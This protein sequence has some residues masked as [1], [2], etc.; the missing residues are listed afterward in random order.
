[1]IRFENL[2]KKYGSFEALKGIT[3]EIRRGEIVGFLG[4]NGAGKTTTMKILTTFISPTSGT[5]DV[6][7]LDIFDDA[8]EI[9]R[10]IGYLPES[11]PL[12]V[13]MQVGEYLNFM[14][15]ARG[16]SSGEI[17]AGRARVAGLCGISDRLGHPINSLSKGYRQRVGLAQALLHDPPILVLDEPT[18]GLDPNQIVEIRNLI[19]E[20]GAQKTVILSTHILPEVEAT[21]DRVLIINQ[22]KIVADGN[23]REVAAGQGGARYRIQVELPPDV[24]EEGAQRF[25]ENLTGVRSVSSAGAEGGARG[26]SLAT[27]GGV[28]I[29]RE[30]FQLAVDR[31]W[32]LLELHRESL[33]LE[34][35]FQNLTAGGG[36]GQV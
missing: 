28:D 5:V 8:V 9:R 18:T 33:G 29:R 4:P 31:R 34:A 2:T 36:E 16:L 21:T 26:F 30:I 1:M 23:T 15:E 7:G 19:R 20:I 27:A 6:D 25:L 32:I 22:G 17:S 35:I 3:T 13:D 14:G 11:A 10:R 24:S 12:Y